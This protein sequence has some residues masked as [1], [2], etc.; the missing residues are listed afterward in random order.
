MCNFLA[1]SVHVAKKAH[2]CDSARRIFDD[3]GIN[4]RDTEGLALCC[5]FINPGEYYERAKFTDHGFYEWLS[6]G[7]CLKTYMRA[8][9]GD[10]C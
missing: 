7:Y 10:E 2:R 9:Y 6:H 5:G 3:V 1:A 8:G 4:T